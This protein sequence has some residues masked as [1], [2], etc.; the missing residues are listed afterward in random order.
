MR[1]KVVYMERAD[2]SGVVPVNTFINRLGDLRRI[3]KLFDNPILVTICPTDKPKVRKHYRI[4]PT[5]IVKIWESG[6][7]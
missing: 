7:D 1:Y 4:M 5:Q 3:G 2:G 6:N